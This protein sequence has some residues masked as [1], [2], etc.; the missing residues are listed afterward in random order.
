MSRY[1][2]FAV[3]LF[4]ACGGSDSDSDSGAGDAAKAHFE[5][6]LAGQWG[7]DWDNLLPAQQAVVTRDAFLTCNAEKQNPAAGVKVKDTYIESID[8]PEIGTTETTA[9]TL[10]LTIDS[11]EQDTTMHVVKVGD[12]WHWI[13]SPDDIAAYKAGECPD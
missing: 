1:L 7:P 2:L 8:V 6:A 13:L 10:H 12:A 9:V 3:L 5:H 11:R 4:I